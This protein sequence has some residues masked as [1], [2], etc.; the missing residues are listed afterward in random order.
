MRRKGERPVPHWHVP[1]SPAHPVARA[2]ATGSN[3]FDA[4]SMQL[5]TPLAVIGKRTGIPPAR[6]R[7]LS[8]GAAPTAAE[9]A[10]LAVLWRVSEADVAASIDAAAP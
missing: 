8:H 10:A 1:W 7:E 9:L 6:C 4:W 5:C 3:W 2:I